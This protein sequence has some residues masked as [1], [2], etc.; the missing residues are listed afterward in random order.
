MK[1]D[2]HIHTKYSI[3]SSMNAKDI[4][5]KAIDLKYDEIAI[6]E[7]LELWPWEVQAYGLPSLKKYHSYL[8]KLK[9]DYPQI[10]VY[11]GLEIGDY[12]WHKEAILPILEGL[13]FFPIL[14]SIHF[15]T[16]RTDVA[17]PLKK[18]LDKAQVKDYYLNNLKLV[19]NCEIDVL[20]HL[21]VYKRYYNF[22]PDEK[23]YYPILKDIFAAMIAKGISLEINLMSLKRPFDEIL[24][25]PPL[26]EL[27]Y[28]M[29]GKLIN[30]GSDTHYLKDFE[31]NSFVIERYGL[32]PTLLKQ[33]T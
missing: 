27:Y 33:T 30:I 18:P 10:K 4:I 20:A 24:P 31:D 6:T 29:G 8:N 9:E 22:C 15:I 3:D 23:E 28:D 2:Y 7:H 19:E 17:L 32:K 14:G 13:D 25:D 16:D 5:V 11:C 12:H 21:G 1:H 26:L